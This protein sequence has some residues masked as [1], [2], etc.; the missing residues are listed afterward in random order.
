MTDR[1]ADFP[2]RFLNE[3]GRKAVWEEA[4]S[5]PVVQSGCR[6]NR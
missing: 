3:N 6:A 4:M 5:E 2:V 1:L